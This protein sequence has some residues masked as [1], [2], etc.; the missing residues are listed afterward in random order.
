[1]AEV[2]VYCI[3]KC[4][5]WEPDDSLAHQVKH[6]LSLLQHVQLPA[7]LT[8]FST[9]DVLASH[10]EAIVVEHS[11]NAAFTS[12]VQLATAQ[13]RIHVVALHADTLP[14]EE[15]DDES[16]S[17]LYRLWQLPHR[18]YDGLWESLEFDGAIASRLFDY[19]LTTW[20]L[21]QRGLNTTLITSNRLLLLHGPPG[22]GKTTLCRAL[23]QRLAMRLSPIVPIGNATP[24]P[25]SH[26]DRPVFFAEINS[27]SLFSKWFSESG[28]L[29]SRAFDK[30]RELAEVATLIILIDEVESLTSARANAVHGNEP[31]DAVRV[32]NAVLTE[33]DKLRQCPSVLVLATSNLTN[34]IDPALLDRADMYQYIGPPSKR[35]IYRILQSGVQ[36][37]VRVGMVTLATIGQDGAQSLFHCT[38]CAQQLESSEDFA[39]LVQQ[40]VGLSGRAL[41]KLPIAALALC[42][43]DGP[44]TLAQYIMALRDAAVHALQ[45]QASS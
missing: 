8:D 17:L 30:L 32:V 28:K 29:V 27:H 3:K 34:A 11:R 15:V 26:A 22:T 14:Q 4:N 6:H 1:M 40:C 19:A 42:T 12:H 35:A 36:E 23:A 25:W 21:A 41:R 37:L 44:L 16:H 18:P 45:K 7:R 31:S 13:L 33:L 38:P 10:V 9:N 20:S 5:A 39:V 43:Q 2:H 24:A